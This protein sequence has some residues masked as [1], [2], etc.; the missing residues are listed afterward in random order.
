MRLILET[1]RYVFSAMHNIPQ[2]LCKWF[3]LC[4]A[5]FKLGSVS[6]YPYPLELLTW[7]WSN[8]ILLSQCRWSI[9]GVGVLRQ[10]PPFRYFPN[11]SP[12][13]KHTL[14]IEYHVHIRQVSPH[15]SCGDT[16]QIWM[17][18]KE[19]NRYFDRIET[20]VYGEIKD[21]SNPHPRT[22]HG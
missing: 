20:F 17:W 19:S 21:L 4:F 13:P 12:S 14:A 6:F 7:H 8:V 10:F 2:V 11:F 3:L 15:L 18:C 16:C 9:P 22:L 1:W 5:L